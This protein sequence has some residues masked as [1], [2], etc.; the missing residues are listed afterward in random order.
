M[1]SYPH[2]PDEEVALEER[3]DL[4]SLFRPAGA[5]VPAGPAVAPEE[6]WSENA[7]YGLACARY[8]YAFEAP[9]ETVRYYLV[10]SDASFATGLERRSPFDLDALMQQVAT[11]V[12]VDDA[13][14]AARLCTLEPAR[15]Q[16]DGVS[17]EPAV[18]RE[19]DVWIALLLG[20]RDEALAR[21]QVAEAGL[22]ADKLPRVARDEGSTMLALLRQVLA[23]DSA[24]LNAALAQRAIAVEKMF[25]SPSA[26]ENPAGLLDLRGLALAAIG[27]RQGLAPAT[28]SVYLPL[29]VAVD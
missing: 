23:G 19:F 11:A 10:E 14:L 8:A 26:R 17:F 18:Q 22:A 2:R 29:A 5:I 27:R 24:G 3:D 28:D 9:V 4:Q 6:F 21:L 16:V 25:R 1:R 13:A 20:R 15:Y 12:V 7:A